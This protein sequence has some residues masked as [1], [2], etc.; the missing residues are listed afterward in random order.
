MA[1]ALAGKR[2]TRAEEHSG[3]SGGPWGGSVVRSIVHFEVRPRE[4]E[5]IDASFADL[6]AQADVVKLGHCLQM[7]QPG[8]CDLVS[9]PGA[10]VMPAMSHPHGSSLIFHLCRLVY[11]RKLW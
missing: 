2:Q 10:S 5:R 11:T 8:V 3:L 1:G 7:R 4:D 6:V 9:E